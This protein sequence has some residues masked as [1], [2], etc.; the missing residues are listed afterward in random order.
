M[1]NARSA[2]SG[3]V[4]IGVVFLTFVVSITLVALARLWEADAQH[5]KERELL[6]SGRQLGKALA[7]YAMATPEGESTLPRTLDQLLLDSRVEPPL[8]H[9]RKLPIDPMTG[10]FE[11]GTVRS[12][13][14]TIMAVHSTSHMKP[15]APDGFW[16]EERA[17]ANAKEYSHWIFGP[18]A[19]PPALPL[20][21]VEPA[22]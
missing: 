11:W 22:S 9:L 12:A 21:A 2:R 20:P 15:L 16:P 19:R 17:F 13:D 1:V 8:R 14:G 7:S 5:D 6:W 10:T 18:V 3:F 4:L